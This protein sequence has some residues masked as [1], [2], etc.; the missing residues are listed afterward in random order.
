MAS[1]APRTRITAAPV[2]NP[3][4]ML[5]LMVVKSV[6]AQRSDYVRPSAPEDEIPL[7]LSSFWTA[8]QTP[9]PDAKIRGGHRTGA[10]ADHC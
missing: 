2:S 4:T 10:T 1:V 6:R 5:E 8:C 9:R 7:H 3:L